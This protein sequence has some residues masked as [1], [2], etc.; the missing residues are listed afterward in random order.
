MSDK[1]DGERWGWRWGTVAWIVS[2]VPVL[3]VL[4]IGPVFR[5]FYRD[6]APRALYEVY[7]PVW[8]KLGSYP[9]IG[10]ALSA[11]LNLWLSGSKW[12]AS[13]HQIGVFISYRAGLGPSRK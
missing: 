2:L 6:P 4:S 3:Y 8:Q 10:P 5:I 11:Y 13:S 9:V 12:T 1:P 7:R